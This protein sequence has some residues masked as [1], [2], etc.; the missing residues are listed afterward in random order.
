MADPQ[1]GLQTV[2]ASLST[3]LRDRGGN[4]IAPP[5]APAAS[6]QPPIVPAA[7][8]QPAPTPV[9][10]APAPAAQSTSI[11]TPIGGTAGDD[12]LRGTEGN[13]ALF[14]GD[15]NDR[16]F[17]LGSDDLLF[18]FNGED[19]LIGGTGND[20]LFGE[21]GNDTLVGNEGTDA[22]TGG[23]GRDRFAYVGDAFAN[24][25]PALAGQT[26]INVLN[27][28]DIIGDF[29]IGEDQFALGKF[30]LNLDDLKFQRGRSSEI[31][32]DSN[33]IVL[34]DPFPA[35]GA[36]ARAIANNNRVTADEGAFVYFNS[37]LGLTRFVYSQDLSDGGD[38]SVLAN[39]NNQR[40]DAGLT[41]LNAFSAR[42]FTLV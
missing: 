1:I 36:A 6:V 37:T 21:N 16:I 25:T 34:T 20:Q 9:S 35:A 23:A 17:A 33:V 22:L 24:G 8:V 5:V 13:D 2:L 4:T 11:F 40:G 42:D 28:P 29:T 32:G 27:R 19:T 41:N 31:S 10:P 39:L 14:G 3:P 30:D 12:R 18:G 26:G 15:G 38:I 7:P